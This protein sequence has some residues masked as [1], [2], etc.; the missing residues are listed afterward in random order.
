M[1]YS[2]FS[3]AKLN[4]CQILIL[5]VFGI[6]DSVVAASLDAYCIS[7]HKPKEAIVKS[8]DVFKQFEENIFIDGN[9]Y[10][11]KRV[12]GISEIHLIDRNNSQIIHKD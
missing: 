9:P 2:N 1:F 6:L 11:L 3:L 4:L 10:I 12:L 5:C 8:T 7:S